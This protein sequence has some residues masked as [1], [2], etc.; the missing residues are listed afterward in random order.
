MK[1]IF[2]YTEQT[3]PVTIRAVRDDVDDLYSHSGGVLVPDKIVMWEYQLDWLI[4]DAGG[5]V[6]SRLMAGEYIWSILL[7]VRKP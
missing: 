5:Q 3:A 6:A 4:K 7:E 1:M 2:D